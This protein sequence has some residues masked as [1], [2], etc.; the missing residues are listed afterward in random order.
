MVLSRYQKADPT[1]IP[2]AKVETMKMSATLLAIVEHRHHDGNDESRKGN[3][4]SYESP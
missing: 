4:R 2:N 1:V 3:D